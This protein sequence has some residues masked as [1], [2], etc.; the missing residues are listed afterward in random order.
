VTKDRGGF[1]LQHKHPGGLGY[2]FKAPSVGGLVAFGHSTQRLGR[3]RP[4]SQASDSVLV[5][6]LRPRRRPASQDA[7]WQRGGWQ[8]GSAAT[9]REGAGTGG[10]GTRWPRSYA[11]KVRGAPT[12]RSA[13][14]GVAPCL[15]VRAGRGRQRLLPA[16]DVE[17]GGRASSASCP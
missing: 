8:R 1:D 17:T 16:R 9:E 15:H 6:G 14:W 5:L 4:A 12:Q 13:W 10:A 2:V 3:P 11:P 7:A